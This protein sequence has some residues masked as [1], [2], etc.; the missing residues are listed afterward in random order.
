MSMSISPNL[1]TNNNPNFYV[2]FDKNKNNVLNKL[3][4]K[5]PI[6]VVA[7]VSLGFKNELQIYKNRKL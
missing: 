2:K 5:N 1:T 6:D 3:R 7:I 4:E